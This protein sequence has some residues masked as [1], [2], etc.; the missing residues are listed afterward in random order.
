MLPCGDADSSWRQLPRLLEFL[1]HAGP[2]LEM[3][4]C[5]QPR[6]RTG[7][8]PAGAA[9]NQ[10]PP[11]KE[12]MK[13]KELDASLLLP[14][15][16]SEQLEPPHLQRM[17]HSRLTSIWADQRSSSH[18]LVLPPI[19]DPSCASHTQTDT[20]FPTSSPQSC[21]SFITAYT[22]ESWKSSP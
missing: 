21:S 4:Q 3:E 14:L 9:N 5:R 6:E 8:P 20:C 7:L 13:Q 12:Q 18:V 1:G 11:Q 15:H 10:R 16:Q 22:P 19:T 2:V 17:T